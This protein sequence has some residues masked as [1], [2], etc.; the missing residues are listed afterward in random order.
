[1]LR[2]LIAFLALTSTASAAA[3]SAEQLARWLEKFPKA[4]ADK[5]GTLSLEEAIS[6]R[7]KHQPKNAPQRGTPRSFKVDPGWEKDRFPDHAICYQT[8][9]QLKANFP[10]AVKTFEKPTDGALRIVGTGHS[11]MGPGYKTLPIIC[12]AAGFTQPLRLHTSG[13]ITGSAR[14][15]WEQENGIFQFDGKPQPKL[16]PAIANGEWEA[17]MWGPYFKDRPEFYTCWI[18]FCLKYNPGMKFYLSDGWPQIEQFDERPTSE[19]VF[20]PELI[21]EL[22]RRRHAIYAKLV[23]TLNERYP[24]KVFV[25]PTCDAMVLATKAYLRGELPG[26]EGISSAVGNK[27]EHALW[28]DALGHLGPGLDRLEGYVFYATLY[29][30]SPELIEGDIFTGGAKTF[31]SR[32]LDRAF[33]K[34]AWQAVKGN[35]L[36]G[37]TDK[38]GNGI[39]DETQ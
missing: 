22:G 38:D 27:E 26:I 5:D 24:D 1:M 18:D 9:K 35:A 11:F 30:R 33:R 6:Y 12:K 17:M 2:R 19:D 25:L 21:T 15:K 14:Y 39:D 10:S 3:P 31:P 36:S 23:N 32:E 16:L 13:G 8:P 37:V 28:R 29:G 4:D 20:T 34:I 7:D